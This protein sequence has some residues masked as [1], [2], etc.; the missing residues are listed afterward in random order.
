M[1]IAIW[2]LGWFTGFGAPASLKKLPHSV[3]RGQMKADKID[4]PRKADISKFL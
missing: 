1:K 3:E 2:L 4:L